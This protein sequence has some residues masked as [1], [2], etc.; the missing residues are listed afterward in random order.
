MLEY[1]FRQDDLDALRAEQRRILRI[2]QRATPV[3]QLIDGS[4]T[5]IPLEDAYDRE[6]SVRK[7]AQQ[8]L[9]T[10]AEYLTGVDAALAHED[11][12]D[13]LRVTQGG[14]WIEVGV[15]HLLNRQVG[16]PITVEDRPRDR[17]LRDAAL[18]LL[19]ADQ[20]GSSVQRLGS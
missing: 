1:P 4:P 2:I 17:D 5:D 3:A 16:H 6:L 15:T 12:K 8:I 13:I 7:A 18:L 11:V 10:H 14:R 19:V 20:L 9:V